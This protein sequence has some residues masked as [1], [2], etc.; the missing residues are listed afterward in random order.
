MFKQALP[1]FEDAEKKREELKD[2]RKNIHKE[3]K[4]MKKDIMEN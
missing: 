2:V 3:F 1:F 4:D